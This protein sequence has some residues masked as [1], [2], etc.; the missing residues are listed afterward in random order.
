MKGEE[1]EVRGGPLLVRNNAEGGR[2]EP[3]GED[4]QTRPRPRPRGGK[5]AGMGLHSSGAGGRVCIPERGPG[6]A[7]PC[8]GLA[9]HRPLPPRPRSPFPSRPAGAVSLERATSSLKP[10]KATRSFWPWKRPSLPRRIRCLLGPKPSQPQ[11]PRCCPGQTAP[12]PGPMTRCHHLHPLPRCPRPGQG[13]WRGS[14]RCPSTR[15]PVPWG[16]A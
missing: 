11:S 1:R 6:A 13:A 7:A 12:T 10:V 4:A 2:K 14:M 16:R 8:H 15:W 5:L 3:L 9:T